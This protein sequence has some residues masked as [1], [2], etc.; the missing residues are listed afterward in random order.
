MSWRG[1][2]LRS[3]QSL[4]ALGALLILAGFTVSMVDSVSPELEGAVV[5]SA[6]GAG[7]AASSEVDSLTQTSHALASA[8]AVAAFTGG[9]VSAAA[10]GDSAPRVTRFTTLEVEERQPAPAKPT[11]YG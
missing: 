4:L 10:R 7:F 9:I 2:F 5:A 6:Q 8:G 11:I 1:A 3:G